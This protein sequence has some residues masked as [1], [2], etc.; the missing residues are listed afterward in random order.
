MAVLE[1]NNKLT[2]FPEIKILNQGHKFS[3][4]YYKNSL[5]LVQHPNQLFCSPP[6]AANRS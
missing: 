3:I 5:I 4:V 6:A 2:D 1:K